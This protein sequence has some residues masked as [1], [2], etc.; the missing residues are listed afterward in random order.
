MAGAFEVEGQGLGGA[1]F[2]TW[3]DPEA[4]HRVLMTGVRPRLVPLDATS[5]VMLPRAAFEAAARVTEFALTQRLCRAVG[6]YMDLHASTWGGDGCR[7]HDAVAASAALWPELFGFEP[8]CVALDPDRQGRLVRR[9][10]PHNAE[11]CVRIDADEVTRR[12][13]DLLLA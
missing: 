1:D 6:P 8:A 5:Q 13:S 2:N 4:M 3:S 7:P 10:G 9:D 11:V 12:L